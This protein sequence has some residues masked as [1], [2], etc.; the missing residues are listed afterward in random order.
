MSGPKPDAGVQTAMSILSHVDFAPILGRLIRARVPDLLDD[1]AVHAVTLANQSGLHPLSTV[2]AL[3]ALTAFGVFR[4]VA[5]STF[6]NSEASNLFRDAPG[7]LRNYALFATSEQFLKSCAA[8]GHS[9][10]TGQASH[11]HA[12]GQKVWEYMRD[13]PDENAAFNRGLAEIRKDEQAAIAAAYDWTGVTAVVDVGAGAGALLACIV[14][15]T[16]GVCGILFDR[17]DVL[18]DADHLLRGRGVRERCELVGGSFFEPM[19]VTGDIWILSQVLH[20][21]PEAECQAILARCRERA[22]SGDRLLVVEMVP[23][24]GQ[25]DVG[26]AL[27]DM[28]MMMF[29]GEARQRTVEEYNELFAATGFSPSGVLATGTAFSILE[30]RPS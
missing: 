13:H 19:Q 9:L 6:V 10:E 30:A 1:G 8:L 28:A 29:G 20:D 4:E 26:I 7:G 5:P 23:V 22:R 14:A 15:A 12:L 21:W 18:P 3:R 25:P 27:L 24:P 16:P 17:P 2:R 11:D